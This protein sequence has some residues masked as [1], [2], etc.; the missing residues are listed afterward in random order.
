LG[1]WVWAARG[2]PLS[3]QLPPSSARTPPFKDKP[4][5]D[6]GS[7]S[8]Y[9]SLEAVLGLAL[10]GHHHPLRQVGIGCE[11]GRHQRVHSRVP[12][13]FGRNVLRRRRRR[14]K[15][16]CVFAVFFRV[17]FGLGRRGV[18]RRLSGR[19]L[20]RRF[21]FSLRRLGPRPPSWVREPA[22]LPPVLPPGHSFRRPGSARTATAR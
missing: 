17:V 22:V 21:L 14:Q 9:R 6:N 11:L 7:A 3:P 1:F 12:A 18:S 19:L 16:F 5:L 10:S 4:R 8:I 13:V 15:T 2:Q 20:C